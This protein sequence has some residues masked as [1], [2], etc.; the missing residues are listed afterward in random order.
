MC[1]EKC[2]FVFST[3]VVVKPGYE[4]KS[5]VLENDTQWFE[6]IFETA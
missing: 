1:G 5:D 2:S 6:Q 3:L 4:V